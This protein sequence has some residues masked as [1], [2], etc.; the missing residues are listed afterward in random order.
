MR[1]PCGP[2]VSGVIDLDSALVTAWLGGTAALAD[3]APRIDDEEQRLAHRGEYLAL[4]QRA[5]AGVLIT[6]LRSY[7]RSTLPVTRDLERMSWSVTGPSAHRSVTDSYLRLAAVSVG[8]EET[9]VLSESRLGGGAPEPGG[10]LLVDAQTLESQV[11]PVGDIQRDFGGSFA[12]N[13]I[14]GSTERG[15]ISLG[16]YDWGSFHTL[17]AAPRVVTAARALN[18]RLLAGGP[19]PHS[20]EHVFDLADHLVA[21]MPGDR[22]LSTPLSQT[23]R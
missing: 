23:T 20:A 10:F 12:R 22:P 15:I 7:V 2:I 17:M 6:I 19:T 14:P 4:T 11:G 13:W 5:D 8:A 16:F 3:V 21:I 1:T 9:L 18:L